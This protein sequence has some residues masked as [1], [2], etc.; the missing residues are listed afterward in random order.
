MAEAVAAPLAKGV[1]KDATTLIILGVLTA[2]LGVLAMMSPLVAGKTVTV[3]I[4]LLLTIGGIAR[5]FYAFKAQ[6]QTFIDYLRTEEPPF[7][8]EETVELMKI[9]IGGLISRDEGGRTVQLSE[10]DP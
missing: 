6:L 2:I 1:K 7:P 10:I 8:F 5:T 9:I 3:M 4:G